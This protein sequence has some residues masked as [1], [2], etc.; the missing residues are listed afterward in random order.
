MRAQ[1]WINLEEFIWRAPEFFE[2]HKVLECSK[3]IKHYCIIIII[4]IIIIINA[5]CI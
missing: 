2:E 3:I 5:C 1:I 4:I